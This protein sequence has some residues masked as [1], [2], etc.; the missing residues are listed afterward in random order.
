LRATPPPVVHIIDDDVSTLRATAR[1][2]RS[3]GFDSLAFSS[4]DEFLESDFQRH[5]ACIVADVHMPGISALELPERLHGL[6]VDIPVIFVTA[7][8]SPNT[9]ERVRRS[10]GSAYFNKPVDDQALIDMIRWAVAD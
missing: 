6:G 8:Y 5:H 1:L 3:A 4:V 2:L 7:D 9:R 10:G